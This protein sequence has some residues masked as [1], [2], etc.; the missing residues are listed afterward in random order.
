MSSLLNARRCKFRD[1]PGYDR[2]MSKLLIAASA[3][4]AVIA[5]HANLAFADGCGRSANASTGVMGHAGSTLVE[6]IA[7]ALVVGLTAF[8]VKRWRR[9]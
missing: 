3:A 4:L 8:A 7:P 9:T 5:G 1:R 6:I 2:A